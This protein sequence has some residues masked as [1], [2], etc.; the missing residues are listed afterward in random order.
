MIVFDITVF[1][2]DNMKR[3]SFVFRILA[4]AAFALVMGPTSVF[5]QE[6]HRVTGNNVAVYNLAGAVE[7]VPGS[8]S[9]V[10]VEI[11]R[12]GSDARQLEIDVKEV[13]G[14]EALVI[15]YPSD[16]IVYSEMGRNSTSSTRVRDDGT[17][18]RG[19]G[20]EVKISGSGNGL[21]AWADLRISVPRGHEFALF[22]VVGETNV[23]NV[24]GNILVDTG[25]GAVHATAGSGNLDIDTGSGAITVHGFEGE[26]GVDT[27]SG[28]VEL[29]DIQGGEVNV[30][31][32]SGSVVASGI[33]AS[34]LGVDTGSGRIELSG[35]A[36]PDVVL[37]TGSGSVEVEL[38][39][40]VDRLEI[41]TGSGSVS[42]WVNETVGAQVEMDTGSG[43]IDLDIPLEV[44][45]A[46]RDYV[47]G[48][49]GDGVGTIH[50]D[51][52]SGT[53]RLL[54]R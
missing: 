31:T 17:F 20:S 43:G 15:R 47:R 18:S 24:D 40:D 11:T 16:R 29:G 36:S 28:A 51:T 50:I 27:G 23:R 1:R 21:E 42:V 37:D 4:V 19:R 3:G 53:I 6:E 13:E 25:S 46:K 39:E 34:S 41:D 12:G 5:G 44:R 7:I 35:I 54:R 26:L 10:V 48:I 32:G 52:G 38:L 30:D 2:R 8:G 14:R 22:L 49:L 9:D 33:G 45:E